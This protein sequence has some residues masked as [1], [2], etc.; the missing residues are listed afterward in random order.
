M[1]LGIDDEEKIAAF[2]LFLPRE[3][4]MERSSERSGAGA[5]KILN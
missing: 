1:K 5:P 2:P 3:F 4:A